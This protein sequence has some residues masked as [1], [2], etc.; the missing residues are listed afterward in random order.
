MSLLDPLPLGRRTARNRV[1]FGPHETNLGRRRAVSGRHVAY[2]RR[3][4]VGGAGVVVV[5]TA[6]VHASDWPYERAPLAADC[7]DGWAAVARACHD[8]GALAI[9]SLG[10]AGGQGSSA[11]SQSALWAPGRVPEVASRE[12]PKAME[13][14]DVAAVVAGFGAAA[15][16]A[17]QAGCDGVEVNAGQHSL[18][19]QFLSGLTNTRADAYGADRLRFAREVLEAVRTAVGR[20]VVGLRLSCDELAPWAGIVPEEGARIAAELSSPVDYVTVVRGSIYSVAATRPDAHTPP[21]FALPLAAGV[22]AA[23]P[24]EVRVV[25]QGSVVDVATAERALADG[26]CDA[27]EMTRAQIADPDL[28]RKVAAGAV[29]TVRPCIL[30]NQLCQVRDPRNPIVSCVGEPWSGHEDE[31]VPLPVPSAR[32]DGHPILVVGG[33]VA[34]LECARVAAALGHRVRLVER[35]D[36]LGG[37]LRTAA[38]GTGRARLALLADWLVAECRRLG[39]DVETGREVGPEEVAGHP[40]PVVLCTGGRPGRVDYEV[41][42]GAVR[43]TAEQVL[44]AAADGRPDEVLPTGPIAVWDPIGGPIGVSVAELLA[45]TRT[46][47][48]VTPDLLVGNELARTGD[49]A[50]ASSRLQQAA[51]ALERRSR[52]LRVRPGGV[53]VADTFTGDVREVKA[54]V[55]VDAGYRLP[56]DT[57]WHATGGRAKGDRSAARW[58]RGIAYAGDAVAPRSVHEAVLEGRRCALAMSEI[59]T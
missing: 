39:V 32:R 42:D 7:P 20:A 28:V 37:V 34:G 59:W 17:V 57:L 55:L 51:V 2:Y 1:V 35:T 9:A 11:Y 36:R 43:V 44:A 15:A 27:V 25:G 56:E 16:L 5:E 48:L 45:P 18:V 10:H 33:G 47:S 13:A 19:R 46:V 52:L 6:S 30:C 14:E 21:G 53:E 49:L 29:A 26:T 3:R 50:A 38:A 40:G 22:R 24:A 31:E 58:A 12:V 54:D 41:E 23:V 4:A 8:E